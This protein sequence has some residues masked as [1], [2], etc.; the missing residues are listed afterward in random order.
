MFRKNT[1]YKKFWRKLSLGCNN[2]KRLTAK[3]ITTVTLRHLFAKTNHMSFGS[4]G[5]SEKLILKAGMSY[6][7]SIHSILLWSYNI[8]HNFFVI[9]WVIFH[10]NNHP[11]CEF[12]LVFCSQETIHLIPYFSQ[13]W[14][15]K[16]PI[17]V[18][19]PLFQ[20]ST[21][22]NFIVRISL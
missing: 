16:Y 6:F 15:K 1:T 12:R 13:K 10:P 14:F 3:L 5:C 18:L 21:I 4:C 7:E 22:L 11:H 17:I 9:S 2:F 19:L 8:L 20:S